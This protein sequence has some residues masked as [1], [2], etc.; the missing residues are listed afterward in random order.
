MSDFNA[1]GGLRLLG[2]DIEDGHTNFNSGQGLTSK[3]VESPSGLLSPAP[4]QP[5]DTT[6]PDHCVSRS[7]DGCW[8]CRDCYDRRG[9]WSAPEE[10]NQHKE[11]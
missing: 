9:P 6:I 3:W 2:P 1:P 7:E 11:Q 10:P 5:V 4:D 8:G